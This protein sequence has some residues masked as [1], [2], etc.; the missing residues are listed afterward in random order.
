[1]IKYGFDARGR[2]YIEKNYNTSRPF[3]SFS[4]G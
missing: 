3:A 2:F 1:M 4:P